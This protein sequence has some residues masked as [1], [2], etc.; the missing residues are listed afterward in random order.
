MTDNNVK[1]KK[2]VNQSIIWLSQALIELLQHQKFESITISQ[3]TDHAG[4]SRRTFYRHFA[5]V[6]EI[7]NIIL[8]SE[9]SQLILTIQQR[10]PHSFQDILFIIFTFWSERT[11]LLKILKQNHLLPQLLNVLT[12][13]A[14]DSLLGNYF[15]HQ[16]DYVYAFA[17]G[18]IWNI[19]NYWIE[20]GMK[21]SPAKMALVANQVVNHFKE[22]N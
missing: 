20:N 11:S 1:R 21:E 15:S 5:K 9:V 16:D 3:L 17:A 10:N 14:K 22:I 7:L 2:Q 13:H 6:D 18:G 19:I 12:I 4:I 8:E